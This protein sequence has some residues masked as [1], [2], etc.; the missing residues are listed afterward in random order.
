MIP[1]GKENKLPVFDNKVIAFQ[2]SSKQYTTEKQSFTGN[3]QNSCS[4]K[5]HRKT[6][7][8]VFVFSKIAILIWPGDKRF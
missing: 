8:M 4:E 2:T 5:I 1:K 3:L 7:A 6:P